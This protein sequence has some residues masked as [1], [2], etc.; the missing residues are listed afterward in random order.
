[1]KT[2]LVGG[3]KEV[4][5]TV[6]KCY[7]ACT[8]EELVRQAYIKYLTEVLEIPIANISVEKKLQINQQTRRFDI[9]ASIKGKCAIVVECKAPTVVISEETL[10]Q[11]AVYNSV[12][13]AN[14]IVLF[15]GESQLVYKKEAG[16]YL[17]CEQLPHFSKL[18]S[19]SINEKE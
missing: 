5:D 6:R 19:L 10:F 14:Y 2:R 16:K 7:V 15:N 1:V 9:V 17:L 8:P 12:L 11:A 3:K 13:Q 4:F 18:K